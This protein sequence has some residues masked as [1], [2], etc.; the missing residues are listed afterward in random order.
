MIFVQRPSPGSRWLMILCLFSETE[1]WLLSH[2][3]QSHHCGP[4]Q[5]RQ[6]VCRR[7]VTGEG[8]Q[9]GG[10]RGGVRGLWN[11]SQCSGWLVNKAIYALSPKISNIVERQH[12]EKKIRKHKTLKLALTLMDNT[13]QRASV[14]IRPLFQGTNSWAS[15]LHSIRAKLDDFN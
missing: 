6:G 10:H 9:K 14:H 13:K 8:I 5:S 2:D 11:M 4:Q 15:C 1:S 3:N 12:S 7:G